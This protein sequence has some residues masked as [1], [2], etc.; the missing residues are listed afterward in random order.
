MKRDMELIRTLLLDAEKHTNGHNFV[1]LREP[2]RTLN[3]VTDYHA[4]LLLEAGL[5]H[6]TPT[7]QGVILVGGLTWKG[8]EFLDNIRNEAVWADVTKQVTEKGGSAALS[9]VIE[10]AKKVALGYFG[11][12]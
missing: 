8:H 10:L 9:V 3:A 7:G 5:I 2:G 11:L 6:A 12:G 1:D 4:G